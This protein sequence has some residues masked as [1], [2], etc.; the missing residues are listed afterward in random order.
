MLTDNFAYWVK[1]P[2][3]IFGFGL[4]LSPALIAAGYIVGVN[5]ALSLLVGI[6]IGWLAGVPL[7][8]WHYG[9]PAADTA[10]QMAMMI[11]RA[12]IRYIGVGTMLVGGIWTLVHFVQTSDAEY[13][14]I[15]CYHSP[16]SSWQS[17]S[18]FAYRT[19]YSH[20]LCMISAAILLIPIF[21]LLACTIIPSSSEI[22]PVSVILFLDSARFIFCSVA[23]FSVP[24]WLISL[25]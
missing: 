10:N 4:G 21:L 3:T 13:G 6:V 15:V 8:T 14:D 22:T 24:S 9:F 11:W 16:N 2:T 20:S 12:H 5:V 23:L 7:L 25:A 19:R 1:T 18:K 17:D